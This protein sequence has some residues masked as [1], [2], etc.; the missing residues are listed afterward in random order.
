MEKVVAVPTATSVLVVVNASDGSEL[1]FSG[2]VVN[3]GLFCVGAVLVSDLPLEN[4]GSK[5]LDLRIYN[6]VFRNQF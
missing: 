6:P 1:A 2:S 5:L 3:P 4:F